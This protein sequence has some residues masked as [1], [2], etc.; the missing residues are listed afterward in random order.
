M[1]LKKGL[2]ITAVLVLFV[3]A[4]VSFCNAAAAAPKL[5]FEELLRQKFSTSVS[6]VIPTIDV[7][8]DDSVILDD[9]HLY[10]IGTDVMKENNYSF[11]QF[12][13]TG[14]DFYILRMNPVD[15]PVKNQTAGSKVSITPLNPLFNGYYI[16]KLSVED[17]AGNPAVAYEF[18]YLDITETEMM[19]TEPRLGISNQPVN[20]LTIRT[21]RNGVAENTV[22]KIGVANPFYNFDSPTLKPFESPAVM[23]PQ[24][25]IDN[26]FGIFGLGT[27]GQFYILCK[28]Q[29]QGRVSQKRFDVGVDTVPPLVNSAVFV[30]P[31]IVEYPES[32]NEI[33]ALLDITTN[34]PVICRYSFNEDKNYDDMTAFS[35]FDRYD[36][37]TYKTENTQKQIVPSDAKASY[38]VYFECEDKAGWTTGKQSAIL[39]V[40]LSEGLGISVTYPPRYTTNK[41]INLIAATNKRSACQIEGG[42]I[43]SY[44]NMAV[45]ESDQKTY[46]YNLGTLGDGSYTYDIDCVSV[47][48]AIRQ[49]QTYS[50]T[51]TID[52]SKP[53][54]PNI[55]GTP[56]TCSNDGFVF[57][58]ALVLS[59]EDKES[60]IDHFMIEIKSGTTQILNWTNVGSSISEINEGSDGESIAV[61]NSTTYTFD[62]KAVNGVGLESASP[63]S[64]S[65]K[66]D[67]ADQACLEKNPP[68]VTINENKTTG[69]TFVE[70]VCEDESG[71]DESKF[72]YGTGEAEKNCTADI[73]LQGPPFSLEITDTQYVCYIAYDKVGNN[74]TG[75]KLIEIEFASSCSDLK[76]N[77]DETDLDCGGSCSPCELTMACIGDSDCKSNYCSGGICKETTCTD[78]IKNGP[79][80]RIES[81][82][83]CG[84]YCSVLGFKCDPGKECGMDDD[85]KTGFCNPDIGKCAESTCTDGLKGPDEGDVDCGGTCLE[86]CSIDSG[87]IINDDCLTGNC[88]AGTC[89]EKVT[90]TLS[91][92]KSP[93]GL[94]LIIFGILMMLGGSGYLA[95]KK[96]FLPPAKPAPLT[97]EKREEEAIRERRMEDQRR[98][99]AEMQRRM[100]EEQRKRDEIARKRLD[101]AESKK[102]DERA[103]LF[104]AFGGKVQPA[105]REGTIGS[106][107][108]ARSGREKE[109]AERDTK[110]IYMRLDAIKKKGESG[111]FDALGDIGS[112][113]KDIYDELKRYGKPENK[114]SMKTKR[115]K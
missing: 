17:L 70:L 101:E 102:A 29:T 31:K 78:A 57:S 3:F 18:F 43:S 28:D 64:F 60:G 23:K 112:K 58:P 50:Y 47:A 11:R 35:N 32:G 73:L 96:I 100:L 27:S 88:I 98:A 10:G 21:T 65:V 68:V 8:F 80:N 89:K 115:R 92:N 90:L 61:D 13:A 63:K 85:C 30:P 38:T 42:S 77:G 106:G 53:G 36:V 20:N 83:D 34:E 26:V 46:S 74:A 103:K 72:Y 33:S 45:Y 97:P 25:T 99:Q 4:N 54:S 82:I 105:R 16:L 114:K 24:H 19:I 62:V 2:I 91:G 113:D 55:T 7:V 71:C 79:L 5:T 66:Y 41:T 94:I 56:V 110:N 107:M 9:A 84:G 59:A 37:D 40:D 104:G 108:G 93:F 12:V 15:V 76:K 49:E 44:A 95:Y 75:A 1:R 67:P 48:A 87:C 39:E 86:K 14:D 51:F 111:A 69:K 81:D 22:C 109:S 52:N 6:K